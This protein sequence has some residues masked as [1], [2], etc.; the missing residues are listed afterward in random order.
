MQYWIGNAVP[1]FVAKLL[2][3]L[4]V[5]MNTSMT[6]RMVNSNIKRHRKD[7]RGNTVTVPGLGV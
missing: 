3:K 5:F 6:Y 7:A 4:M 1:L 2:A